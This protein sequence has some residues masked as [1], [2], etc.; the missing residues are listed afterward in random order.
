[1]SAANSAADW[2]RRATSF[3]SALAKIVSTS[4]RSDGSIPPS[5]GLILPDGADEFGH[6]AA[7]RLVRQPTAQQFVPD[8]AQRVDVTAGIDVLRG[9]GG[10]LLGAHVAQR[11]D[12]LAGRRVHRR[13][14]VRIDR[15]CDAEVE[16]LRLAR[17]IDQPFAGLRSRWTTPR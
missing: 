9:G 7:A 3:S 2:Y 1:M 12:Q 16:D 15:S 8:H 17:T 13:L 10:E 6:G 4:P 5:R 11:A 14:H